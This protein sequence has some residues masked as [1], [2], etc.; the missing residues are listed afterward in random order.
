M[1]FLT[2]EFTSDSPELSHEEI[3]KQ[4]AEF[5]SEFAEHQQHQK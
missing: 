4:I 2:L 5:E 1:I 3:D